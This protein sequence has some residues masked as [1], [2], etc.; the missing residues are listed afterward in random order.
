[1]SWRVRRDARAPTH[2]PLARALQRLCNR[3]AIVGVHRMPYEGA[4]AFAER[5]ARARPDLAP[6]I[7]A[8]MRQYSDLRYGADAENRAA[9]VQL[10]RAMRRFSVSRES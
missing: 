5:V 8:L 10:T 3:A 6:A 9:A 2:D 1:M 4:E 7:R